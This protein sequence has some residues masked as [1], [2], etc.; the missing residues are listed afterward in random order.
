MSFGLNYQ[1]SR[2][3]KF[4][5]GV[6]SIL[7][8]MPMR[9]VKPTLLFLMLWFLAACASGPEYREQ[10]Q[11]I[12]PVSADLARV[13]FYRTDASGVILQPEVR[14]DGEIIGFAQPMGYFYI[15]R[16]PGT[17]LVTAKVSRERKLELTL[18]AGESS[19]VR[20][21][22][23][24]G[25]AIGSIQPVLV[26]A[27]KGALEIQKTRYMGDQSVADCDPVEVAAEDAA[28]IVVYRPT[29]FVGMAV[30]TQIS[31]DRCKVGAVSNN[32]YKV[33]LVEPGVHR[34]AAVGPGGKHVEM[35]FEKGVTYYLKQSVGLAS[36]SL[37]LS[38]EEAA[39]KKMSKLKNI[40]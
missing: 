3:Q 17:Y 19:Y 30:P 20:L 40:E 28:R 15:D 14:L 18:A 6:K 39:I 37:T 29:G 31:I 9:T 35:A 38:D 25:Y 26:S 4:V 12:E 1:S 23:R 7:G 10:S 24:T 33:F 13:Y 21:E 8:G 22:T 36:L 11:I 5:L 32:G 27:E 34:V 16:P 2:Y